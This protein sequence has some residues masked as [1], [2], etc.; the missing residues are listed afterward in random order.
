M[1]RSLRIGAL[2]MRAH[3]RSDFSRVSD[4]MLE[5][6]A[7]AAHDLDLLVVPEGTIPAYVLGSADIDD[8]ATDQAVTRI[9][10][11][12]ADS[13]CVIVAGVAR[14]FERKLYNSAIVVDRDGSIAGARD[15]IFLWAFDR[16][17]FAPGERIEPIATTVGSLGVMICAD[18]RM[19][20][21]ARA[22]VDRGAEILVMPTAWVTSG[23]NPNALEN[24]QA[25]LLAHVRAFE[26]GVPFVAANKVGSERGMVLYCGKSQIV[27]PSG[28][29]LAI[30]SQHENALIETMVHLGDTLPQRMAFDA[31]ARVMQDATNERVAFSPDAPPADLAERL[32]ILDAQ[33][34]VTGDDPSAIDAQW[35]MDPG[36]LPEYRRAGAKLII[37]NSIQSHPWLERVA[38][39]RAAELRLYLIVFDRASDR[40]YAIDPD[41]AVFAGTTGDLRIATA[42]IDYARTAQTQVAPGTD[43]EAGIAAVARII[44]SGVHA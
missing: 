9:Q 32:S 20:G 34:Y 41:G 44:Q 18:G 8:R 14:R 17:W 33:R 30:A 29:V 24:L 42:P 4:E 28:E 31:P 37:V 3:D 43:V 25:D 39:A 11:I 35:I 7:H 40:A 12:A 26:N 21:I 27:A 6:I 1:S 23:R 36:F 19:P 15:K 22:L 5:Q 16:K 10:E 2:Q 38:R 13:A